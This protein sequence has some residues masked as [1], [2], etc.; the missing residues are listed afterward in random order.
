MR[1]QPPKIGT[2]IAIVR[3]QRVKIDVYAPGAGPTKLD[4]KDMKPSLR[5]RGNDGWLMMGR[6]YHR[7]MNLGGTS[8]EALADAW[9]EAA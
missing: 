5:N 1:T 4:I 8:E 7:L 2:K 3:G 9:D 6:E